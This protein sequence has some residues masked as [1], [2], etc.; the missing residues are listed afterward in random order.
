M[1]RSHV[2]RML[3]AAGAVSAMF[4]FAPSLFATTGCNAVG[5]DTRHNDVHG[6][7]LYYPAI[8]W[9]YDEGIAEGE[10]VQTVPAGEIRLFHPERPINRAEFTKLVLLGSGDHSQPI[11]CTENPFPDVQ[12]D[13]WYAPYVC[14]AK[15]KG[16]ISGFPDGTFRPGIHINFAEGSKILVRS[17]AVPTEQTDLTAVDGIE[18]WYKPYVLAL[19]RKDAVAPTV[20]AFDHQITRGEMAEMIYRLVHKKPSYVMPS[21]ETDN[22]PLGMGYTN[23][24]S[25]EFTLGLW[26]DPPDP[27]YFFTKSTTTLMKT[28]DLLSGYKFFHVLPATLRCG[29]SGMWEH[30][31]AVFVDWSIGMYITEKS[32]ESVKKALFLFGT[33]ETLYFGGKKAEC[34]IAGVEGENMQFCFVPLD[35][36]RTL[37]VER[38]FID[39]QFMMVPGITPLKTSNAWFARIRKSMQFTE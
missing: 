39:D 1:I 35:G 27:P 15:K 37:I 10:F 33:P 2:Q 13:A 34:V 22:E 38:E 5:W 26:V 3:V 8:Q 6:C 11:A 18:L 36:T 14:A 17:F 12:K 16:I 32:V 28:S 30:C 23:P 25:L 21:E 24:F 19:L 9:M 7:D 4:F 20:S 29:A 31:K